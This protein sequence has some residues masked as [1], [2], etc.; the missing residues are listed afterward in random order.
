MSAHTFRRILMLA[1]VLL[2]L[3]LTTVH[4]GSSSSYSLAVVRNPNPA[5]R[6]NLRESTSASS[7]SLGK[8]Y[9]GTLVEIIPTEYMTNW[10]Y[11]R[12][13][14]E[15]SNV[16]GY[17]QKKY[18][19]ENAARTGIS[20]AMPTLTIANGKG[21]GLHLRTL[22]STSGESIGLYLNGSQVQVLGIT[23]TWYHVS[24][25]GMTGYMSADG[26][27]RKLPY[28]LSADMVDSL[29]LSMNRTMFTEQL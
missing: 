18:L 19:D 26:F 21:K 29:M 14:G 6:L 20:S 4:A 24:I 16:C 2:L 23:P 1:V 8:Y 11:V 15:R 9:N 7:A 5:D 22:P 12:I 3:P 13:G 17:M 25:G 28:D 27:N 10:Y